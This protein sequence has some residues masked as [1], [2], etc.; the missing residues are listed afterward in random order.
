MK[1]REVWNSEG[2]GGENSKKVGVVHWVLDRREVRKKE[3]V[4]G[5]SDMEVAAG[6]STHFSETVGEEWGWG[7]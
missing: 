4:Y 7:W 2:K 5:C 1:L 6:F 3:N